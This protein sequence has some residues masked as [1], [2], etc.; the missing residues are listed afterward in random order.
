MSDFNVSRTG[1]VEQTG[2]AT[3]LFRKNYLSE[4]ISAYET[5]LVT[6]GKIQERSIQSGKSAN[7]PLI[8]ELAAQ[9]HVPG[10]EINGQN[11]NHGETDIFIDGVTIADVAIADIDQAMSDIDYRGKYSA[12]A[13]SALAKA[14]DRHNLITGLKA[15][16]ATA[17]LTGNP[18]G[19][20]IVGA[21]FKTS[22][23][24]L[25][26]GIFDAAQ[27]MDEKEVPE[28]GRYF[29]VRPAQYRLLAQNLDAI[30]KNHGGA[31]AYSE[32]TILRVAGFEMVKTNHLP[33]TNLT[34][35]LVSKYNGDFSTTAGLAMQMEAIG[36]VKLMDIG[37][38]IEPSVRH[39]S[40]LVVA[41]MAKGHDIL[42]P[43]CAVELKTA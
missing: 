11:V 37:L 12:K 39:Q 34:A 26:A 7:F 31:G 42:R 29:Y 15:A 32:G 21:N 24:D 36:C 18:D 27:T 28:E 17:L 3:A 8:G 43:E 20:E 16:R 25:A 4:V 2:D 38:Q 30:N 9:M 41:R 14:E 13:G 10:A 33:V 35:E 1:Q 6:S 40:T 22:A 19:A 23:A 5:K